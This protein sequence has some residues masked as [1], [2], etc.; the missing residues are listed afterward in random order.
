MDKKGPDTQRVVVNDMD[1]CLWRVFHLLVK[2]A[3]ASIPAAVIFALV[4][5]AI[6]GPIRG[7]GGP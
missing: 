2:F 7:L 1:S 4:A 5:G 3:V 6:L